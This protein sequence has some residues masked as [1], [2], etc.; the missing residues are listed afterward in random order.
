MSNLLGNALEHGSEDSEVE[1]SIVADEG[2]ILFAVRNEGPAIPESVLPTIFDPLVRDRSRDSTRERRA[3]S[4]GLGLYIAH[5]IV[6]SHGGSIDVA[7]SAESGT[8]FSVRIP[9]QGRH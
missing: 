5:E 6:T 4:V 2:N 1:L 9:R 8:V 3:G 7:S